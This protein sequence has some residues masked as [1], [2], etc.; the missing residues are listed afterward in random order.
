MLRPNC[1]DSVD[2]IKHQQRLENQIVSMVLELSDSR[3]AFN[4]QMETGLMLESQRDD[5]R[6]VLFAMY[7]NGSCRSIQTC[8]KACNKCLARAALNKQGY[9]LD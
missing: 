5:L 6:A 7:E 4:S 1:C 2:C 3:A 8:A 9:K